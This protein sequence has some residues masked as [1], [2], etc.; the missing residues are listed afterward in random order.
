MLESL[1]YLESTCEHLSPYVFCTDGQWV[2]C[3]YKCH[4]RCNDFFRLE[5]KVSS[6]SCHLRVLGGE[7]HKM[8]TTAS[9]FYVVNSF[10]LMVAFEA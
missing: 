10:S 9:I 8:L 7:C 3:G 6:A 5:R 1:Q 2:I 4:E